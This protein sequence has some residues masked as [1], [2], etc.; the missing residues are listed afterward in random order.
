LITWSRLLL[1]CGL[2]AGAVAMGPVASDATPPIHSAIAAAGAAVAQ[3]LH[4]PID[5]IAFAHHSG[6]RSRPAMQA[7]TLVL[8]VAGLALRMVA[9]RRR[10]TVAPGGGPGRDGGRGPP[11]GRQCAVPV[12]FA[13]G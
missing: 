4:S 2:L 12:G 13:S 3:S 1:A 7:A 11:A 10:Q 5:H 8:L 6:H 9:V